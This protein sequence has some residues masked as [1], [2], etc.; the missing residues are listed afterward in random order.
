[1]YASSSAFL[2][3]HDTNSL[4]TIVMKSGPDLRYPHLDGDFPA[5][6]P[7][8]A[9]AANLAE[10]SNADHSALQP[11]RMRVACQGGNAFIGK[12]GLKLRVKKKSVSQFLQLNGGLDASNTAATTKTPRTTSQLV[13]RL[14][15]IW[16]FLLLSQC[17]KLF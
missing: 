15:V 3:C 9:G 11:R 7:D 16:I 12:L 10:L 4:Y 14:Q 1:L 13:S 8:P 5:R 2:T 17:M 6:R